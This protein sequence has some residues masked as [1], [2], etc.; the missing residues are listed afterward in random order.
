[1]KHVPRSHG[2]LGH[3]KLLSTHRWN[4]IVIAHSVGYYNSCLFVFSFF[5]LPFHTVRSLRHS[6]IDVSLEVSKTSV[7]GNDGVPGENRA[8]PDSGVNRETT[9][10]RDLNCISYQTE[11]QGTGTPLPR[12]TDLAVLPCLRGGAIGSFLSMNGGL[13][14]AARTSLL[15]PLRV[16][17]EMPPLPWILISWLFFSNLTG[18]QPCL[19]FSH[20]SSAQT[21]SHLP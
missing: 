5:F 4:F 9:C 1:M 14:T 17:I 6:N 16:A 21:I 18:R 7:L 19:S 3:P 13:S 11:F 15:L 2:P 20:T 8:R 12:C 10:P